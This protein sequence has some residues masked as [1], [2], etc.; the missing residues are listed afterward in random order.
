M[1]GDALAN[2]LTGNGGDDVLAGLGG[3]DILDGGAG[4]DTAD[5]KEKTASVEVTLNGATAVTVKVGGKAEDTIKNIEKI[6]GG[7][8]NDRL[9]GDSL[10]NSLFGNAG[11]DVLNGGLGKDILTGGAGRDTFV[12]STALSSG[13]VDQIADFSVA[14]D[15]IHLDDAA[16]K[17]LKAGALSQAAFWTGAAAH[18]ADDRIIYNAKTGALLYDAD[19][20]GRGAAVQF[21]TVSPNLALTHADFYVV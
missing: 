21:A 19:G 18:D 12:F 2:T 10:A 15:T 13:N 14:D 20:N 5:Y 4:N 9:T 17:A 7:Q 8:A 3:N 11:D 16:F 6:L 1:T